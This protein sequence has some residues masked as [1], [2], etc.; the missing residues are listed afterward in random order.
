MSR[1]LVSLK[2]LLHHARS[3]TITDGSVNSRPG[4]EPDFFSLLSSGHPDE[5]GSEELLF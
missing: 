3:G 1:K 4:I 2:S 5:T